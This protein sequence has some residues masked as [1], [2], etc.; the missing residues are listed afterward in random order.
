MD[1]E[2]GWVGGGMQ[3]FH[4]CHHCV[5]GG[6]H[7]I[8]GEDAS[9]LAILPILSSVDDLALLT[10]QVAHHHRLWLAS[11]LRRFRRNS[12][13]P[14]RSDVASFPLPELRVDSVAEGVSV[15]ST[16]PGRGAEDCF[17]QSKQAGDIQQRRI[18]GCRVEFLAEDFGKEVA[19]HK[20][21]LNILTAVVLHEFVIMQC[22]SLQENH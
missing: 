11:S 7:T 14:D 21:T 12:L 1:C 13:L 20:D 18:P 16:T 17:R 19:K 9:C 4:L 8:A 22:A 10:F 6:M 5:G 15:G 3:L 2:V